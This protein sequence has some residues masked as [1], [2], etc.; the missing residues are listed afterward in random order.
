MNQ[1]FREGIARDH[2]NY[3]NFIEF[4]RS[5][6]WLAKVEIRHKK[7][8]GSTWLTMIAPG[9]FEY[10]MQ[11]QY[12]LIYP[13]YEVEPV[14]I[15]DSL[16]MKFEGAFRQLCSLKGII[17]TT[18]TKEGQREKFLHEL[19]YDEEVAKKFEKEDILFFRF[20]Y[21]KHRLNLRTRIGYSF[22]VVNDYSTAGIHLVILS[23]IRL[24]RYDIKVPDNN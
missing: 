12:A 16:T 2:L 20:L 5:R 11:E 15:L 6:T 17:V 19:I 13:N 22:M 10:F 23:F 3:E 21:S 1:F 18:E 8:D 7:N 14:L 24:G 4:F 9:L